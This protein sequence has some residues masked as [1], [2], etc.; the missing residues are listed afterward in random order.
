MELTFLGT[1]SMVPTKDRNVIGHFLDYNGE[2]I[3]IDCG[4][5][6]QR[7]MN[8]AGINRLRVKKILITHWHGDHVA[9]LL[10][11][12]QTISNSENPSDM[13][14]YGPIGSAE[15]IKKMMEATLHEPRFNMEV[16]ELNP[17][18]IE[19][20]YENDEYI[21]QCAPLE[22]SV[23]VLGYSFVE[24]DRR[25]MN[26]EKAK[27]LGL[28]P[29]PLI[30]KLK[31]G[32]TVEVKGKKIKPDD[33]SRMQEGKKI[34]FILDTQ[35]CN[36][37]IK[38]AENTD[39]LI[40]EATYKAELE[41]KANEYKHMTAAQAATIATKA[42]AK[43]LVITHFSQR[44]PAVEELLEEASTIFPETIAAHDFM[45]LKL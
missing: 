16:T 8:V 27:E 7:Q 28:K 3:L 19:T 23:P 15:S 40:C 26:M 34:T 5:G 22:P 36:N 24:K 1:A 43:K 20:F 9:G 38:L 37:C 25:R 17:K 31:Q 29:G 32:E 45:K 18:G 41:E 2:G 21:L 12:P 35:L 13:H 4:E 14:L 33:V 44:Y 11:L 39:L 42:N 6:T 30:G 10:G